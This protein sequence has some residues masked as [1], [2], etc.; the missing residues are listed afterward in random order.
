MASWRLV[1]E[2]V[3]E[4][5][6]KLELVL[7]SN[8]IRLLTLMLI[9]ILSLYPVTKRMNLLLP[10]GPLGVM[11]DAVGRINCLDVGMGR[12]FVTCRGCKKWIISRKPVK[13]SMKINASTDISSF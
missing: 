10:I 4:L 6:P 2:L 5:F 11:S 7:R 13:E 9:I 3:L 1:L 8:I 12:R